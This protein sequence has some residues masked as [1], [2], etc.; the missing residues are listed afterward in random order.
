MRLIRLPI[1]YLGLTCAAALGSLGGCATDDLGIRLSMTGSNDQDEAIQQRTQKEN[2][3]KLV[4]ILTYEKFINGLEAEDLELERDLLETSLDTATDIAMVKLALLYTHKDASFYDTD[5]ALSI[6]QSCT[7]HEE[8]TSAEILSFSIL[9]AKLLVETI[10]QE[11][12]LTAT[13][14]KLGKERKQT[15][16]LKEQLD[17]LKAIEESIN[18]RSHRM[19]EIIR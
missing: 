8:K 12:A 5:R 3:D 13:R 17:A 7:D 10:D 18:N 14:K 9:L 2:L 1:M 16:M 6:L 15:E 11:K 4:S 19:S